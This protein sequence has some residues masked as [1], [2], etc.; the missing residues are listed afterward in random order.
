[1]TTDESV[2]PDSAEAQDDL[3]AALLRSLAIAGFVAAA[4][5]VCLAFVESWEGSPDFGIATYLFWPML[6][7]ASTL[8]GGATARQRRAS[9]A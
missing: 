9:V 4:T 5:V 6:T 8:F 2:R 7:S 3:L 1:M